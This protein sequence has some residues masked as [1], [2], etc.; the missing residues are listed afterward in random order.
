V[1]PLGPDGQPLPDAER[2]PPFGKALRATSLD[3]LPQLINVVRGDM[4]LVGPRPLLMEY[5]PHYTPDE[6][7]RHEVRPGITGWAQVNGR[8]AIGWDDKLRLDVWYVDNRSLAL[9]LKILWLTLLRVVRR[10]G[11]SA[12]GEA[13]MPRLDRERAGR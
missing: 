1:T 8:N 4:S 5:L 11:V 7:R 13:T 9:D 6:A 2:L 3:E 12:A 10:S